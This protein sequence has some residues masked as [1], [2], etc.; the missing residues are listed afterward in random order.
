M[1][2]GLPDMPLHELVVAAVWLPCN[3]EGISQQRDG[4]DQNA[5]ADVDTHAQKS[6]IRNSARP[7]RDW[8]D[9]RENAGNNI[10]EA[11]D[12]PDDA[13]DPEP[14]PGE[15]NSK[16]FIQQDL[17]CAKSVVAEEPCTPVPAF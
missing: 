6:D 1:T 9:E 4:A 13:I 10:A 15:G 5:D 14:E 16:G 17:Q 3:V 2:A 7:S 12:E 8:N 11:G